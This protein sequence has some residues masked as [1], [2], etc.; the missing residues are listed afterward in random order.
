MNSVKYRK[1]VLVWNWKDNQFIMIKEKNNK[2]KCFPCPYSINFQRNHP[3][4]LSGE[5]FW[6]THNEL[7]VGYYLSTNSDIFR[8]IFSYERQRLLDKVHYGKKED[9]PVGTEDKF[10]SSFADNPNLRRARRKYLV[11]LDKVTGT[12]NIQSKKMPME[13]IEIILSFISFI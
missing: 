10:F 7:C 12:L 11:G 3:K 6:Q 1:I 13:C 2:P 5:A 4:V 8:P 9:E